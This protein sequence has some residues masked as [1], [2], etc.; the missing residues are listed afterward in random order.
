[1]GGSWRKT[2]QADRTGGAVALGGIPFCLF[3]EQ[4]RGQC[5]Q[6]RVSNK[7]GGRRGGQIIQGPLSDGKGLNLIC[8]CWKV[9]RWG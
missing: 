1:M 5:G 7:G 4:Q 9:L 3:Q 8:R 6:S 2:S